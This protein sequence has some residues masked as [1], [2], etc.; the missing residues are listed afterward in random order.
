M[1]PGQGK[2]LHT[3]RAIAARSAFTVLL[4]RRTRV[5]ATTHHSE[6]LEIQ[7]LFLFSNSST[8]NTDV[9][10]FVWSMNGNKTIIDQE[11]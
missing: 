5:T 8:C 6:S 4:I 2:K 11:R 1:A 10:T 3:P 9:A 7:C